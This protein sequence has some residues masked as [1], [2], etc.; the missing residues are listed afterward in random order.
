MLADRVDE[1]LAGIHADYAPLINRGLLAKALAKIDE[2]GDT[3]NIEPPPAKIFECLRGPGID[4][5]NGFAIGQDPYPNDAVGLCFAKERAAGMPKSFAPVVACLTKQG[6]MTE[7]GARCADLRAWRAQGMLL[8]NAAL[9]TRRGTSKTHAA[10][11]RPFVV[12]LFTAVCREAQ[13]RGRELFGLLWGGDARKLE[14][15]LTRHGHAAFVWTHPS[16]MADN[17]LPKDERFVN[18]TNFAE[19]NAWLEERKRPPIVWDNQGTVVAFCDGSHSAM[20]RRAAF[21]V[22]IYGGHFA[23]TTAKGLLEAAIYGP[24][25]EKDPGR[26]F[27]VLATADHLPVTSQRAELLAAAWALQLLLRGGACGQTVLCSDSGYVVGTLNGWLAARR[28]KGTVHKLKNLDLI[29]VLEAL[30]ACLR[31]RTSSL[32]LTHVP[33]H[34]PQLSATATPRQRLVWRG[35]DAA[36]RLAKDARENAAALEIVAPLALGVLAP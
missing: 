31:A 33:A 17:S 7:R 35:N 24:V 34:R 12:D 20:D 2:L 15:I 36:D 6:L 22:A 29:E 32:R 23:T 13:A 26:G 14:P 1:L 21:G 5:L 30:F 3:N 9:T 10:A 18:C 28:T 4:E 25:D 8:P 11:W 27:E 19:A 16:P